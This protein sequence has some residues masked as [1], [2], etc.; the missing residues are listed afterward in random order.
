MCSVTVRVKVMGELL[1]FQKG[2]ILCV[3]LGVASVAKTATSLVVLTA[4]VSRFM[5]A[6]TNLGNTSA[7]RNSGQKPKLSERDLHTFNRIT[8]KNH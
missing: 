6:Y 1:V 2:Q 8:S 3:R 7:K 4:A 5:T